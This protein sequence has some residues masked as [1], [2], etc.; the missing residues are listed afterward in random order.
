MDVLDPFSWVQKGAGHETIT[1]VKSGGGGVLHV[2]MYILSDK[3][4]YTCSPT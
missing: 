3:W 4:T 2:Y 1:G